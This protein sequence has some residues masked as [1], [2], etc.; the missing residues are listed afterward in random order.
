MAP[1][2]EEL[3]LADAA[4][5]VGSSESTLRRMY[6]GGRIPGREVRLGQKVRVRVRRADVLAAFGRSP[7]DGPGAVVAMR[8]RPRKAP[9]LDNELVGQLQRALSER[10]HRISG[11][12][13]EREELK[14]EIRELRAELRQVQAQLVAVLQQD[15]ERLQD[16]S[17][18][19]E[20][21]G[22]M[23]RILGL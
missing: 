10:E 5:L 19:N 8:G 12:M 18:S 15:R 9:A 6:A 14:A 4:K 11:L 13:Q 2:E 7:L 17:A 1:S 23:R 3:S 22:L 20:P 21:R 16:R